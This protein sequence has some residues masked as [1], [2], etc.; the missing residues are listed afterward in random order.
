MVKDNLLFDQAM[1]ELKE[2]YFNL[3][4]AKIHLVG[5]K[6]KV[7]DENEVKKIDSLVNQCEDQRE[8]IRKLGV[9]LLNTVV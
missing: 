7:E 2:S 9:K 3:G 4:N 6:W 8:E 1:A 5:L